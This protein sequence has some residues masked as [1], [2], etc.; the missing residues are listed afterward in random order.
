MKTIWTSYYSAAARIPEDV[1]RIAIS[2]S[3][4]AWCRIDRRCKLLAPSAKTFQAAKSGRPWRPQFRNELQ[5]NLGRAMDELPDGCVLLCWEKDPGSCHRQE[6][7]RAL[8]ARFGVEGGEYPV[9]KP[10]GKEKRENPQGTL[11]GD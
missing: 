6:V 4:P 5:R 3:V 9:P 11:F 2:L 10:T 8:Q 1:Q 7:F